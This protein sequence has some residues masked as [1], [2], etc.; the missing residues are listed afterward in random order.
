MYEMN[1]CQYQ[2]AGGSCTAQPERLYVDYTYKEMEELKTDVLLPSVMGYLNKYEWV[3]T[4]HT[5]KDI[6][7]PIIGVAAHVG[8]RMKMRELMEVDP[9]FTQ[10]GFDIYILFRDHPILT[11]HGTYAITGMKDD[12]VL[13]KPLHGS[14]GWPYLLPHPFSECYTYKAFKRVAHELGGRTMQSHVSIALYTVEFNYNPCDVELIVGYEDI[15]NRGCVLFQPMP[16]HITN[17]GKPSCRCIDDNTPCTNDC[18]FLPKYGNG[19][20]RK[21]ALKPQWKRPVTQLV[22]GVV[23]YLMFVQRGR[24]RDMSRLIGRHDEQARYVTTGLVHS[25]RMYVVTFDEGI[26]Q[27]LLDSYL[28]RDTKANAVFV[29]AGAFSETTSVCESVIP[30]TLSSGKY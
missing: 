10:D 5:T 22:R 27:V 14:K 17:I 24:Q 2:V 3:Y 26:P 20:V 23:G 1:E 4:V 30:I 19:M 6:D 28:P 16:E 18:P 7:C 29:P 21:S 25:M 12:T 13:L 9:D 15:Y 8:H 11:E